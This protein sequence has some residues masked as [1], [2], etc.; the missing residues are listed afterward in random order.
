MKIEGAFV[1]EGSAGVVALKRDRWGA[2]IVEVRTID[3]MVVTSPAN[4]IE[5]Q[6]AFCADHD[7]L[8]GMVFRTLKQI[9]DREAK[10][11]AFIKGQDEGGI[12]AWGVK[13]AT[14]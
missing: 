5:N 6:A 9:H 4:S 3:R 14:W 12:E 2:L 7:A 10:R 11:I 13:A 1:Y 8:E